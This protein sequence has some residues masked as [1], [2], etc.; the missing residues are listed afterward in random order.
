[1]TKFTAILSL[2]TCFSCSVTAGSFVLQDYNVVTIED[3]QTS[4]HVDGKVFVGGDLIANSKIGVGEHLTS[5]YAGATLQVAGSVQGS[6]GIS[7][8]GSMEVGSSNSLSTF[9]NGHKVRVNNQEIQNSSGISINADLTTTAINFKNELEQASTSFQNMASTNNTIT[10]KENKK[11][12]LTVDE[13][14]GADDYAVFDLD[15]MNK[16]FS[17]S[18]NQEAEIIANNINDIAGIIINVSGTTINQA[19]NNNMLGNIFSNFREKIL[20]NFYEATTITLSANNFMGT[21]LA[22]LATVTAMGNIDG[23]VGAYS[24]ITNRE[25]HLVGSEVSPTPLVKVNEPATL[26]LFGFAFI[27]LARRLTA[28]SSATK[29]SNT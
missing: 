13:S 29:F 8:K 27:A 22:P 26:L 23:A 28:K 24:L 6:S 1:M 17:N 25:I 10:Y 4:S 7:V 15:S 9:D 12:T 21:L 14:L 2:L 16:F 19:Q 18:A 20:W 3:F 11:Y 5:P